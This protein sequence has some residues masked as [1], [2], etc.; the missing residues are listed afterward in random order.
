MNKTRPL[1]T[2]APIFCEDF[3]NSFVCLFA[4]ELYEFLIFLLMV[5]FAEIFSLI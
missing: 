4:I 1:K 3:L 2:K 5:F